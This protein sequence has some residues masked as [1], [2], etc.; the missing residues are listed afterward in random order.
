MNYRMIV[1]ILGYVLFF[2]ALFML[3]PLLVALY[4]GEMTV[5]K[6][7]L[8]TAIATGALAFIF[9]RKKPVKKDI[10]AQEG[11]IIVALAWILLS[12]LGAFPYFLSDA[13]PVFLNAFFESVS[14]FTTTG[15]SVITNIESLPL[16]IAFWRSLTQWIGGLGVLV[17][18]ISIISL[19]GGNSIYLMKAEFAGPT[20][21]KL[22]P[23]IGKTAKILCLI[24]VG[25][26]LA[27]IILLSVGGMPL[28]DSIV[29]T[30]STASTGGFSLKNA[31]IAAYNSIY[32]ENVVT[33]FMVLFAL[34]FSFYFLLIMKKFWQALHF[35]EMWVY[36]AIIF[37]SIILVTFNIQGVIY[38]NGWE[39]FHNASFNVVSMM[40]TGFSNTDT[41]GWPMFSQFIFFFLMFIGGCAGSTA[42]GIKVARILLLVK[43]ANLEIRKLL[44]PRAVQSLHFNGKP[45]D[46]V[47]LKGIRAFMVAYFAV[48]IISTLIISLD[49]YDFR[50]TI[51]VV[52][53][54][55]NNTGANL[56]LGSVE[57][58]AHL[59]SPASK[60]MMMFNM[61]AGR[62]EFFPIWAMFLPG[63]W[64]GV[65]KN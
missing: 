39:S 55:I 11:F 44:H 4:Y 43:A 36:V 8:W 25:M 10:Y 9:T 58:S 33:V 51:S 57:G 35:E 31:S 46:N 21:G 23:R 14:G 53:T 3:A 1:H 38:Q 65:R 22:V 5:V 50:T 45:V 13:I 16:S 62:L 56:G 64:R 15:L 18:I 47:T 27:E 40:T 32:V 6:A 41:S 48:F 49:G 26:S 29:T 61:L 42:G 19:A 63:I 12:F 2:G 30:F 60:I 37:T 17:F 52:S 7:F 54:T 20:P 28:F 59:F 24:Y 34:S